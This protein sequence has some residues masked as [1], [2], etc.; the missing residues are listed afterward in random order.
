MVNFR[1]MPTPLK[2]ERSRT[3]FSGT[4]SEVHESHF[5]LG[6]GGARFFFDEGVP[7]PRLNVADNVTVKAVRIGSKY[8]AETITFDGKREHGVLW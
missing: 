5:V 7:C 1:G 3:I 8:F 6:T 4:V 2:Q